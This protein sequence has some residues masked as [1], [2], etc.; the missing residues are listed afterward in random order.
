MTF[1]SDAKRYPHFVILSIYVKLIREIT[2]ISCSWKK[3]FV[4][5]RLLFDLQWRSYEKVFY[6]FIDG[7]VHHIFRS[8]VLHGRFRFES[9][10]KN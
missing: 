4:R 2:C 7:V 10:Y 3:F 8:V 9:S 6:W 5:T 1:V